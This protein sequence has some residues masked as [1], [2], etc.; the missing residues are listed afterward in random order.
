MSVRLPIAPHAKQTDTS[1]TRA[2]KDSGLKVTRASMRHARSLIA[3]LA[4]QRDLQ[5]VMLVAINSNYFRTSA[6]IQCA[7]RLAI[8]S[9]TILLSAWTLCVR[10]LIAPLVTKAV[11][12]SVTNASEASFTRL[13]AMSVFLIKSAQWSTAQIVRKI[14]RFAIP[15]LRIIT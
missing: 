8:S 3:W 9:A 2:R 6:A 13:T 12:I 1:V 10:F 5:F 11:F 7:L 15:A 4:L 14:G